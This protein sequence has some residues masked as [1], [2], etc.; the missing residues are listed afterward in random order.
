MTENSGIK[1]LMRSVKA[2]GERCERDRV[3]AVIEGLREELTGVRARH[4]RPVEV[5]ELVEKAVRGE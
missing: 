4:M 5:L 2:D 3:L 1:R